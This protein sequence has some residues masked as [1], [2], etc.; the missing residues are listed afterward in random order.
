MNNNQQVT[1]V[2]FNP[3][4]YEPT[5]VIALLQKLE[6]AKDVVF[7]RKSPVR[8]QIIT[9]KKSVLKKLMKALSPE[10]AVLNLQYV[11]PT[12]KI[13]YMQRDL[14]SYLENL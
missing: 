9:D 6:T 5:T 13:Q 12:K 8:F 3:N 10:S 2:F 4:Y 14:L 7:K 1:T 11:V